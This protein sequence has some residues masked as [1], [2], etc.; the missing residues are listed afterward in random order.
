MTRGKLLT[1]TLAPITAILLVILGINLF[2]SSERAIANS[3]R[4]MANTVVTLSQRF[5]GELHRVAQVAEQTAKAVSLLDNLTEDEIYGLLE[6]GVRQD[7]LI[8]GAAMGFVAGG[9]D[10]HSAFCPYVYRDGV[11]GTGL[12]RLDI[13]STYDYLND[14]DI[15]WWHDPATSGRPVWS[16]PYFD[17]GAGN[18]MMSTYSVPF[19]RD[20]RLRGVTTIDIPLAPL[21]EFIGTDLNVAILTPEGRYIHRTQGIPEGNAT[22]FEQAADRPGAVALARQMIDGG[23]GMARLKDAA[24]GPQLAYFAPLPSAGWS[25]AIFLPE[26]QVL[27]DARRQAW[28][29]AGTMLGTLALIALAMW[30]VAGLVARTQAET[31]AGEARFRRLMESA[32]DA[33]IIVD[34]DARIVMVNDQAT[35]TFGYPAEAMTGQSVDMLVPERFRDGHAGQVRKF[36]GQPRRRDMG[37]GMELCGLR[38]DGSEFPIE[39]GLSPLETSE[40]MLVS[41][42]VR[43]ITERRRAE[44]VLAEQR[45][46]LDSILD[47][48]PDLIFVKDLEGRYLHCN[49]SCAAFMG[50]ER[51][52]I[53]GRTDH[54]LFGDE[55]GD[56]FREQDRLVTE[57]GERR[58]REEWVS[59]PDGSEHLLETTKVPF[60]DSEGIIGGIL[61]VARD[62]TERHRVAEAMA[63]AEERNRLVLESTSDGIF[64]VDARGRVMFIN[65]AAAVLVGYAKEELLGQGIH[66]LIHH[67]RADGRP[68]PV[69]ECPMHAAF[70]DGTT[71]KIDDE[72]L[73][74]KDGS[75][76]DVEYSSTPLRKDG[77]LI[78]AVIVFRDITDRKIAEAELRQARDDADAANHAKSAFLANMSHELRTP[79]NAILGYSEMLI[80]DAEDTGQEDFVPDLKKINQ[81]GAHLLTLINDVLDLSKIES[82]KVEAFPEQI[83]IDSMIDD[84]AATA[85]PLMEKNANRL[86][87][88]R[89]EDLGHAYQ[90]LT[91]VRQTLF[92]LLSNAAKFTHEGTVTLRVDRSQE[93]REDWLQF[94]VS[95]TGIGIAPE[96]ID[97]VFEEFT[98]ADGS[99]TRDY[100]GTGL[101]LTISRRFCQLLGGDLTLESELAK[102]STFTMRIPAELPGSATKPSTAET[103]RAVS[104]AGLEELRKIRPD[105]TILVI[106]DDPEAC[107]IIQRYL[108]KDGFRVVTATSG[109]KGLQIAHEIHP[110]AITLDVMMPEMDGWAVLR[111]LKADPRLR[112][113]PVI[114]LSMI[115]DRTRGYSLGAVDYLTKPVDR[116]Q[117][118]KVLS[119]YYRTGES[120]NVLLVEDDFETREV[121]ARTLEKGGWSVSE[122]GDGQEA[123]GV[124]DATKPRLILLDLMMPVMDGFDFLAAMR[125]RPDCHDIPVIVVTAKDLTE[126]DRNRLAGS[127]EEVLE[128]KAYTR[129]D[130]LE[131]VRHAVASCN[132]GD[133]EHEPTLAKIHPIE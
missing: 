110:A 76:F 92:N 38:A 84:V 125:A 88:E 61:G 34:E 58:T 26:D 108:V 70:T 6:N 37:S 7:P 66:G 28:W 48:I 65:R 19:F 126:E 82:G 112:N 104:R 79:M 117:L 67:S 45:I 90:D 85:H 10:E 30:F 16:E 114:M 119:R 4:E 21:Q 40:G 115:E 93:S 73:W 71:S 32:P 100:G 29:L 24:D 60:R 56:D 31:R 52:R 81:A 55:I 116:E 12:Q 101:G 118:H 46:L 121:M 54:Q 9:F 17:E 105:S 124:L 3:E 42:V 87:I 51:E 96:K 133:D 99:T 25:F 130:L 68:Y 20:S 107:E 122:A 72:V 78:G 11:S 132:T 62:I 8:Y 95:D 35:K 80:E 43:D 1:V 102:G 18:I 5:D 131:R 91:K 53:V 83:D 14:P 123:L 109:Q 120:C 33:M 41:S 129:E 39:V 44:Q 15:R 74:R 22:V 57:G 111:A 63:E 64:G 103:D 106:D 113:I 50:R 86:L 97:A 13:A 127:V 27:A 49:P 77:T 69:E 23:S 47:T 36:F 2:A 128:K 59:Y 75:S 98:Q 94:A 89:G